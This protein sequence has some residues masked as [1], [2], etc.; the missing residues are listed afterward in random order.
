[1]QFLSQ[2]PLLDT[3]TGTRLG[4]Q[5][6]VRG[7]TRR[8]RVAAAPCP[9]RSRASKVGIF[10]TLAGQSVG[11]IRPG[12]GVD[13]HASVTRFFD[14]PSDMLYD[15][16]LPDTGFSQIGG[17]AKFNWTPDA[18]T[19][20]VSS[21]MGTRQ[22]G[23]NRWD[24]LLGGDGN[25]I[26]E[27]NDL[28]LDLFYV[29]LA[30][31]LSG[32]FDHMEVTYSLNRQRE[33]RVNQG[34]NGNPTATI[35]HE[36]ERTTANGVQ[37]SVFKQVS[38][39]QTLRI[40]GE[41]YFEGLT[42]DAFN[43]NPTTGAV[44]PRRPR[45][46]SGASYRNGGIY[47][48]T[49]Y[50]AIPDRLQLV[51]AVRWGGVHYEAHAS[52]A[53]VVNGQPLWPDDEMSASAWTYRVGAVASVTDNW[54]VATNFARGYRAPHMTDVGTLGLTGS[55][56]EVSSADVEGRGATVGSTS[57]VDAVSTG[58]AVSDLE[59]ES[60]LSWDG[61]VRYRD[62]RVRGSFSVFVNNVA[63][64]HSEAGADSAA[65]RGGH[66]P[67]HRGDHRAERQRRRVRRRHAVGGAGARQLRQRA[68][69]GRRGR[70]RSAGDGRP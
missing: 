49:G 22:D 14:M 66:D 47:A 25:L 39:R 69:L 20:I 16:R 61:A 12:D 52:D 56:F 67:R 40:G 58:D 8:T 62:R 70:R 32:P 33:E 51:G 57:G 6:D 23:G 17:M 31:Q 45:V 18:S 9:D 59:P 50:D 54:S 7:S 34:G 15:D 43:V 38:A 5:L 2:V 42:S 41:M 53:P 28:T 11:D 35:G 55:G 27:L 36:P 37:G 29:R 63:R 68:D 24:Q 65:G 26:S 60:S 1:M 4:G 44:S 46:P 19:Q 10:G 13:S 48:Q 64:Q 30:R 3:G 21:Y